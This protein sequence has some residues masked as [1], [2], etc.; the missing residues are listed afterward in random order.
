MDPSQPSV[1]SQPVMAVL[2][3][4]PTSEAAVPLAPGTT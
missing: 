4:M 2:A 3:R 1:V